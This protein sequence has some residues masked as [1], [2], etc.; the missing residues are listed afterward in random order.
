[1][2][3]E[4]S[5]PK[6]KGKQKKKKGPPSAVA[7]RVKRYHQSSVP[8]SAVVSTTAVTF[9]TL[10]SHK[11]IDVFNFTKLREEFILVHT[12]PEGFPEDFERQ[13]QLTVCLSRSLRRFIA[14]Y[15]VR[16]R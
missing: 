1:M 14:G 6:N 4:D 7:D 3:F 9:P 12:T 5:S 10:N 2:T 16:R 11:G 13:L 8:G 15:N